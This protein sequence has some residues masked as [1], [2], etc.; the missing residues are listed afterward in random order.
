MGNLIRSKVNLCDFFDVLNLFLNF[1]Q[2]FAHNNFIVIFKKINS[3][4][5]L[6][7]SDSTGVDFSHSLPEILSF[8]SMKD[9]IFE[10]RPII[11]WLRLTINCNDNPFKYLISLWFSIFNINFCKYFSIYFG[12]NLY[13]FLPFCKI[14]LFIY[15]NLFF[16]LTFFVTG[17]NISFVNPDFA[18]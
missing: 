5:S 1:S 4:D 14:S 9:L 6:F 12:C 17:L 2:F 13:S 8:I 10:I 16:V 3:L 11:F 18:L 7:L 15:L